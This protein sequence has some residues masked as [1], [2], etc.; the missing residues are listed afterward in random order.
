MN[1]KSCGKTE[2]DKETGLCYGSYIS[3]CSFCGEKHP[4]CNDCKPYK[5]HIEELNNMEFSWFYIG[6]KEKN[7]REYVH[8]ISEDWNSTLCGKSI[9]NEIVTGSHKSHKC[10]KCK[11]LK[12]NKHLVLKLHELKGFKCI[13]NH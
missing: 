6:I 8:L 7:N 12:S 13:P 9:E 5:D 3:P 1:C 2:A 4:I 10:G 11:K